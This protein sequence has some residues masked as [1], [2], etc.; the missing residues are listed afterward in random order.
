MLAGAGDIKSYQGGGACH[1]C[2][3]KYLHGVLGCSNVRL[4]HSSIIGLERFK[5]PLG[6]FGAPIAFNFSYDDGCTH[7]RRMALGIAIKPFCFA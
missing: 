2:T 7:V 5:R 6:F 4:M 3:L 1:D